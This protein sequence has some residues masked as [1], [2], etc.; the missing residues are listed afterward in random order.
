MSNEDKPK[1]R[2]R[3]LSNNP[4]YLK[5]LQTSQEKLPAT[6]QQPVMEQPTKETIPF[7][8]VSVYLSEDLISAIDAYAYKLKQDKTFKGKTTRSGAIADIVARFLEN[9]S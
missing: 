6:L 2:Y 4:E 8:A 1:S 3:D 5:M 9:H 7:K